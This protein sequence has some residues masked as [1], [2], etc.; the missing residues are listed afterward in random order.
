M[1]IAGYTSSDLDGNFS[2]GLQDLFLTKYNNSGVKQWTRQRGSAANEV[3]A[4]LAIDA[5]GNLYAAGYTYSSFDG[6]VSSGNYDAVLVKYDNSGTWQW[7]KQWG[8]AGIDCALAVTVDSQGYIYAAGYTSSSLDGNASSGQDDIFVSKFNSSGNRLWTRQR[9]TS[10]YDYAYGVAVDSSCNVFLAGYTSG[11]LDGNSSAGGNDLA[12]VKY[13]STGTWEWTKQ[14]GTTALDQGQ[15]AAVD[16]EGNVYAVGTT[17]GSIDGN[18]SSGSSDVFLVKYSN[19]GVKQWTKQWGSASVDEGYA[20]SASASGGIYVAGNGNGS[21]DGNTSAGN[22]DVFITKYNSAGTSR[23]TIQAG[24][25]GTD[26]CRGIALD[27]SGNICV[28][29]YTNGSLD[30]YWNAGSNDAFLIK[31]APLP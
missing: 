15:G 17:M 8:T 21:I 4:A 27:P 31:F 26:Y 20:V 2:S 30:S 3:G 23:A 9:G 16:S 24:G 14:L 13:S 18:S 12:L 25:S 29:G 10:G 19:S 28:T 22:H 5:S 6:N 7:T 11:P 1:F